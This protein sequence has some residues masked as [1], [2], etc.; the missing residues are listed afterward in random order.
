M[1]D[2]GIFL[3]QKIVK[4]FSQKQIP[5]NLKYIDPSYSIRSTPAN[6]NDS[7][8]C[9]LLGQYAVHAAMAGKTNMVMGHWQGDFVHVPTGLATRE[10]RHVDLSGQLWQSVL[11]VTRQRRYWQ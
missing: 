7:I 4:H 3:K 5:I 10:R 6:A 2:I 9:T 1:Q 11:N 8:Y